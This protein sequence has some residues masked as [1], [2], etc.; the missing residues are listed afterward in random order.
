DREVNIK[1]LLAPQVKAGTLALSDRD[2]LL[3]SMTDEVAALVLRDNY[4]Q[5]L[6]LANAVHQSLSMAGV[7]EDWMR[8]LEASGQVRRGREDL[9]RSDEL[10]I[11]RASCRQ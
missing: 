4:D 1:V 5:N 6:A 9:P 2:A 3:A 8:T 10:E 7:H 11:G